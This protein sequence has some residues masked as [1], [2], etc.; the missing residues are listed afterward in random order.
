LGGSSRRFNPPN[1]IEL[2]SVNEYGEREVRII[3]AQTYGYALKEAAE[4]IYL[5]IADEIKHDV[6]AE[7]PYPRFRATIFGAKGG[8]YFTIE[9]R[10]KHFT[11]VLYIKKTRAVYYFGGISI[12][13]FDI[14]I[15][16]EAVYSKRE[17]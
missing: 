10:G 1:E 16:V 8:D 11:K 7:T 3:R 17:K 4:Y 13:G 15:P 2:V 14:Y 9:I 5:D 6:L 12:A